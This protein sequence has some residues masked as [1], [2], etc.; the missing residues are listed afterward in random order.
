MSDKVFVRMFRELTWE[1]YWKQN[2]YYKY[3]NERYTKQ[4]CKS[5]VL[6]NTRPHQ[7][8]QLSHQVSAVTIQTLYF[9]ILSIII[10]E[11]R[12]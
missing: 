2:K 6:N 7:V 11:I 5:I 9:I 12:V 1:T 3:G 8:V 4:K 10:K